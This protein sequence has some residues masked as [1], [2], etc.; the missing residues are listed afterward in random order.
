MKNKKELTVDLL[1]F[2][3]NLFL[4]PYSLEKFFF[5][6]AECCIATLSYLKGSFVKLL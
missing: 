5:R 1:N 2:Q 3:L 4:H 6:F